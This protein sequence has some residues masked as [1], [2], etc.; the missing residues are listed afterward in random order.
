MLFQELA[1]RVQI[2]FNIWSRKIHSLA[3]WTSP[4]Q[5]NSLIGWWIG[6][7]LFWFPSRIIHLLIHVWIT[8]VFERLVSEGLLSWRTVS[9]G[10]L[11]AKDCCQ[12]RTVCQWGTVVSEGL[13]S[14]RDCCQWRIVVSEGLLSMRDCCQWRTVVNE[15]LLSVKDCCHEGLLSVRDCCQWRTVVSEGLPNWLRPFVGTCWLWTGRDAFTVTP[16]VTGDLSFHLR[17]VLSI[18]SLKRS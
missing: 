17:N 14:V 13:L 6:C 12:W 3:Y 9:E 5:G 11:S 15:G 2:L 18:H 7:S 16:T 8:F 4:F 1:W 10:L